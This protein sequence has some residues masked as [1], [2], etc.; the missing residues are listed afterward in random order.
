MGLEGL[1]SDFISHSILIDTADGSS[2][3]IALRPCSV[4]DFYQ[5]TMSA[6]ASLGMPATIWTKP[7]EVPDRT[8]FDKDQK[9]TANDPEYAQRVLRYL[10]IGGDNTS[11]SD[12]RPPQFCLDFKF[13]LSLGGEMSEMLEIF[14]GCNEVR[15]R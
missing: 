11:T 2:K 10:A 14:F 7:V 4:A 9:H 13:V 12:P 5:E 1:K 6:L 15:D 8:P 3:T